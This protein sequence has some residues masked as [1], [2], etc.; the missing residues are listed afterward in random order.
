MCQG[1][2]G[3][4]RTPTNSR[5]AACTLV[6]VEVL[7]LQ[8]QSTDQFACTCA[9]PATSLNPSV[10]CAPPAPPPCT[11]RRWGTRGRAGRGWELRRS[12]GAGGSGCKRGELTASPAQLGS[13]LRISAP[14]PRR[15]KSGSP[16]L[17]VLTLLPHPPPLEPPRLRRRHTRRHPPPPDATPHPP[18]PPATAAATRA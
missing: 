10:A 13:R 17:P 18:I 6:V 4:H 9:R 5:A 16:S 12:W 14:D 2:N 1:Y 11:R 8:Q 7:Q 3:A 15:P